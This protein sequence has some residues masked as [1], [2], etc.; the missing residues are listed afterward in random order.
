LPRNYFRP[1]D[2]SAADP[3]DL[4]GFPKID[5]VTVDGAFGG[6]AKAQET[7][8]AGGGL[9]DQGALRRSLM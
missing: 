8:F 2:G 9:F 6:W 4:A 5:L 1:D 7:H 3:A